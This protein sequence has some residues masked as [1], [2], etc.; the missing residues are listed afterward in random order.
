VVS[1]REHGKGDYVRRGE[2]CGHVSDCQPVVEVRAKDGDFMEMFD[3]VQ[4]KIFHC[5]GR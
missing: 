2:V 3:K 1:S 4:R 5:K